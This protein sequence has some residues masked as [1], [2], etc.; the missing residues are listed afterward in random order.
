MLWRLS[1]REQHGLAFEKM[2]SAVDFLVDCQVLPGATA[3]PSVH[4]DERRP[5]RCTVAGCSQCGGRALRVQLCLEPRSPPGPGAPRE[6]SRVHAVLPHERL[7]EGRE[8]RGL[9]RLVLGTTLLG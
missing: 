1:G 6:S 7:Q 9:A 3:G 8:A 4:G 5:R 2:R